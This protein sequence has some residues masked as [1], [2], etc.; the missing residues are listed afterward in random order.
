MQSRTYGIRR[1][2]AARKSRDAK[3]TKSLK[4]GSEK[5]QCA[6]RVQISRRAR[7]WNEFGVRV[8]DGIAKDAE[9]AMDT[10]VVILCAAISA[11]W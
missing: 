8:Q 10:K 11:R 2:S 7:R 4:Q 6:R 1:R 5:A 9:A 3:N